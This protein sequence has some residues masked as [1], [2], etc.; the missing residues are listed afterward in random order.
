MGRKITYALEYI[1]LILRMLK[2]PS[3]HPQ[4]VTTSTSSSVR[5]KFRVKQNSNLR[6]R[7][8][9]PRWY[10]SARGEGLTLA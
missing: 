3:L 6:F 1:Y 7:H 4:Y 5:V 10:L 2:I 9:L 8:I